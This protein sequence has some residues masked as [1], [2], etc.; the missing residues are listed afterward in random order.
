MNWYNHQ[1]SKKPTLE[2]HMS[3]A[4][5]EKAKL[6]AFGYLIFFLIDNIQFRED[7]LAELRSLGWKQYHRYWHMAPVGWAPAKE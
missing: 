6:K 4:T 3:N 2:A 5:E 1:S 7:E